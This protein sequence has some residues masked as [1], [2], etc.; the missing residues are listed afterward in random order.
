MINPPKISFIRF[1]PKRLSQKI[2]Y[3]RFCSIN[4]FGKNIVL[5]FYPDVKFSQK[6]RTL[7]FARLFFSKI[8]YFRFT[9]VFGFYYKSRGVRNSIL[10]NSKLF[11]IFSAMKLCQGASAI[12]TLLNTFVFLFIILKHCPFGI[13][14]RKL[15]RSH[16][17]LKNHHQ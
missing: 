14:S 1:C 17:I 11:C 5:S 3:I 2:S 8:S 6:Y 7:G 9:P 15:R 12:S 13:T 10:D 4:R 16:F